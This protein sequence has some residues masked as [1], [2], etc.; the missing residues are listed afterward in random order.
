MNTVVAQTTLTTSGD[1]AS[2]SPVAILVEVVLVVVLIAAMWKVF[3]KAGRPGWAAIIPIYNTITLL[4]ITGKSGWWFLG[5]CVPFLNIYVYIRLMFNLA[6][7]YGRSIG[8]GFGLLF[9]APIFLLILGFG[10]A[11]Y[12][13]PNGK[14]TGEMPLAGQPQGTL[15]A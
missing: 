4:Q 13:G 3:A 15:A 12:V 1:A 11:E 7:V 5:L 14:P 6:S 8:F 2:V 9:L 10:G